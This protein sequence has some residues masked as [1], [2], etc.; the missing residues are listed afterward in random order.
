MSKSRA[1]DYESNVFINCP[2]DQEYADLFLPL[3]FTVTECGFN[4][5]CALEN[6]DASELRMQKIYDL[7]RASKYGI[8]DLSRVEIDAATNLPH[9]NMPLELGIFLG[10]KFLG[11][12]KQRTKC[13]LIF[14]EQPYRYRMYLSDIAGQDIRSHQN[15]PE[16][17]V[18]EVRS[19]LSH[20]ATDV[21]PGAQAILRRLGRFRRE[22]AG[23]CETSK[24]DIDEL[25]HADLHA[26]IIEFC[27]VRNDVLISGLKNPWGNRL[28]DPHVA[29]IREAVERTDASEDSF[30]I[31]EKS[32][33]GRT[34]MQAHGGG[35]WDFLLEYQDG[36]PDH[37]FRCTNDELGQEEVIQ[38]LQQ[39]RT[40]S[41]EWRSDLQWVKHKWW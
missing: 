15:D 11:S 26:H 18:S 27:K 3:I 32:G 34:F 25:S 22:L 35:D 5:S 39:F 10:A 23:M 30:I 40:D 20:F 13:C 8:H 38:G 16:K 1:A 31:L 33:T 29:S 6:S 17:L 37:H 12:G 24:H 28:E 9:F 14:D 36:S 2:F 21:I 7:I 19:W 4:A 41:D